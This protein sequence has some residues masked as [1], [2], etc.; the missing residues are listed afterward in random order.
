MDTCKK[1]CRKLLFPHPAVVAIFVPTAAVLLIYSFAFVPQNK[2]IAYISYPLSAYALSLL[3]VKAPKMF[4]RVRRIKDQNKY[5]RQYVTD[6]RLRMKISLY[7]SLGINTFYAL[8]QFISGLYYHAFWFY[9]L[10]GY[11]LLLALMRFFLLRDTLKRGIGKNL[12]AELHRYRFCGIILLPVNLAL[13]VI[14]TFI[15]SQNRGFERNEVLTIAMALYTFFSLTLSII[16]VVRYRRYESPILSAAKAI[17]LAAALV[18]LL[19][20]ETAML[21]AFGRE[22]SPQFR[23][24]ITASTGSAVCLFVLALAVYMIV[25]ATKEIKTLQ[26]GAQTNASGKSVF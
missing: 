16:N 7:F 11:Y 22:S 13:V 17:N 21:S 4:H 25:H 19:S 6:V 12:A 1:I 15:V 26:K 8:L 23:Q 18:S 5:V 9:A 2:V 14:V 10:C 3:C 20:L 24:I